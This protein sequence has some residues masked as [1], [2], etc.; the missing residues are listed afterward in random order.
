MVPGTT[1]AASAAASTMLRVRRA[2]VNSWWTTF[3]DCRAIFDAPGIEP[4][5]TASPCEVLSTIDERA[6]TSAPEWQGAH[7]TLAKVE[8]DACGAWVT[9][10]NA[11][12]ARPVVLRRAGWVDVRG[13]PGRPLGHRDPYAPC[14]DR[15]GL[16]PGDALVLV[17]PGV[18]EA[19]ESDQ[20]LGELLAVTGQ[21]PSAVVDEVG[22]VAVIAVPGELGADP[23]QRVAD[24]LGVSPAELSLPGYPLGDIQPEL[25]H[26]PPR[27]PRLARLRLAPDTSTVPVVRALL[28]RLLASWRLDGRVDEHGLK[29]AATE[30]AA[31][32]V[33]HSA[34]PEVATVRYLGGVVRVEVDD[35][36]PAVPV[37][38]RAP[39]DAD[40][41]RGLQFVEAVASSWGVDPRPEGK[42]VWA[43]LV[44]SREPS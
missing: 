27:P 29:L 22:D 5:S 40:S 25:W 9:V 11:S 20:L 16:G 36:S 23:V 31:N 42:R 1:T 13:H 37:P 28:E 34:S 12:T 32:A 43:E 26:E 35:R 7:V 38:R 24:A 39:L 17:P 41:G 19:F 44:V 3:T 6:R 14:D 21:E 2:G 30:L 15:V 18:L 8:L 33:A 4:E 10:A